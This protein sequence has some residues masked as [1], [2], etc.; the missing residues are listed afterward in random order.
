MKK[1]TLCRAK[2]ADCIAL[3]QDFFYVTT[4]FEDLTLKL[5]NADTL[6]YSSGW[7]IGGIYICHNKLQ[8][9]LITLFN[10]NKTV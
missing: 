2:S 1:L 10:K 5:S 9:S 8:Y 7:H 6:R 4:G 3:K